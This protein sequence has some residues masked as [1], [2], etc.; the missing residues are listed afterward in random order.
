MLDRFWEG[1]L[2][3]FEGGYYPPL[4]LT[5]TDESVVVKAELPGLKPE[6]IE[7]SVE[8]SVL[9]MSGEKRESSE[10]TDGN[11]HHSERRYGSFRRAVTLPS[12]IDTEKV[13]TEF[14]NGVLTIRLPKV[15]ESR[16][17]R[18]KVKLK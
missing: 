10:K 14:E 12:E 18:I 3:L 16:R 1:E 2:P 11:Y 7:L 4:E 17:K 6:D 9:T 8:G 13:T 5:D 15:E